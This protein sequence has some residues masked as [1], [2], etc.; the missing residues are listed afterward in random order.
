MGLG[1]QY[2]NDRDARR[3]IRMTILGVGQ[4]YSYPGGLLKEFLGGDVPLGSRNR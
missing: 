1:I 3:K 2:E 4:V